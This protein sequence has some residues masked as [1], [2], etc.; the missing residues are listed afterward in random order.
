MTQ[1]YIDAT[2]ASR[3]RCMKWMLYIVNYIAFCNTFA[4]FIQSYD[5]Y[6]YDVCVAVYIDGA[7]LLMA[8]IHIVWCISCNIYGI[9]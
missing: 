2:D 3:D 5:V 4:A 1:L 7:H 8:S 9:M 6:M